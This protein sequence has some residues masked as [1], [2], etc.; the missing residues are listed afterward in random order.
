METEGLRTSFAGTVEVFGG[1]EEPEKANGE[2]VKDG[3]V[4]GARL[5]VLD[6][7]D[8]AGSAE[9]GEVGWVRAFG[10]VVLVSQCSVEICE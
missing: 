2:E 3:D 5:R 1:T 4:G 7:K 8:L 9:D 6:I 10:W